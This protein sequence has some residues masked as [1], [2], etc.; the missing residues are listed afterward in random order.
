MARARATALLSTVILAAACTPSL[1]T[2]QPARTVPAGHLAIATSAE[3]SVTSGPMRDAL[4]D[5]RE[6]DENDPMTREELQIAADAGTAALT[7]APAVGGQIS[8][9]YGISKRVELDVRTTGSSFGAGFRFQ[10][11]RV[12]PGFYGAIGAFGAMYLYGYPIGSFTDRVDVSSFGRRELSVPLQF[13][14]SGRVAHFW[15]GPKLV[16]ADYDAD[17]SVCLSEGSAGACAQDADVTLEGDATYWAGQVGLAVGYR[18][19]W[20]AAELSVAHVDANADLGLTTAGA[21][22]MKHTFDRTGTVIAPALG[23][24]T[25]F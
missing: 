13:G 4:E 17:M 15:F 18:R 20:V 1:T 11:L 22:P 7:Q 8:V 21:P 24:I 19:F 2:M 14:W 9:A 16:L 23:I 6:L 3:V 5:L 12:A 10:F 25:W